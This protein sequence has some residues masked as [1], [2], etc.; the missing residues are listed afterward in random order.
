MSLVDKMPWLHEVM[1]TIVYA[2]GQCKVLVLVQPFSLEKNMDDVHVAGGSVSC[3]SR[4][5]VTNTAVD[6]QL[7]R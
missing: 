1:A 2:T 5:S 3:S 6:V 7:L 4:L